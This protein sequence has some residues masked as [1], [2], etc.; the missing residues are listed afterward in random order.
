LERRRKKLCSTIT[1]SAWHIVDHGDEQSMREFCL[2]DNPD[3][4]SCHTPERIASIN[5]QIDAAVVRIGKDQVFVNRGGAVV[6]A[7][8]V[9]SPSS[10]LPADTYFTKP[11]SEP[12]SH[13]HILPKAAFC[14]YS[15]EIKIT[16]ERVATIKRVLRRRTRGH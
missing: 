12:C 5:T 3:R 16:K 13:Q 15:K 14:T 9:S 10:F 2:W 6:E 8:S 7:I 4:I 1:V 11:P